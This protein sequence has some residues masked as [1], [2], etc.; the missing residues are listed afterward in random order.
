MKKV[1]GSEGDGG[2][3]EWLRVEVTAIE[4]LIFFIKGSL[5]RW[6]GYWNEDGFS[7]TDVTEGRAFRGCF[8]TRDVGAATNTLPSLGLFCHVF[9]GVS[10]PVS[11]LGS[12]ITSLMS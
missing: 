2:R 11:A 9:L 10:P 1:V 8:A 3:D 12:A 7:W 5:H 4:G 6:D